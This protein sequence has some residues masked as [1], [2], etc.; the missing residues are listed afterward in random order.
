MVLFEGVTT[1]ALVDNSIEA[2]KNMMINL[3]Y[4]TIRHNKKLNK[5]NNPEDNSVKKKELITCFF[6]YLFLHLL[7]DQ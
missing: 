4:T 3:H 1:V 5:K 7:L 6:I 2:I